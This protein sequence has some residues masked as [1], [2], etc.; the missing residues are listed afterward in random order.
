MFEC[1]IQLETLWGHNILLCIKGII[2][3]LRVWSVVHLDPGVLVK[4]T[5]SRLSSKPPEAE[6][7]GG[8]FRISVFSR[9]LRWFWAHCCWEALRWG[10]EQKSLVNFKAELRADVT[11]SLSMTLANVHWFSYTYNFLLNVLFTKTPGLLQ[12]QTKPRLLLVALGTLV[13]SS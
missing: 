11:F 4:N 10:G 8:G 5:D 3:F 9:H 13:D 6:L 12:L 2:V 7:R 1:F